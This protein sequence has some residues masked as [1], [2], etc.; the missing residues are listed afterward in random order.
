M[1]IQQLNASGPNMSTFITT[2]VA[3]LGS[4]MLCW[5]VITQHEGYHLWQSKMP[6]RKGKTKARH[7]SGYCLTA[8]MAML[9]WLLRNGHVGWLKR[10]NAW[11]GLLTNDLFGTFNSGNVRDHT[12][13]ACDFVTR[14]YKDEEDAGGAFKSEQKVYTF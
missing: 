10:S 3:I 12:R 7:T 8:R 6:H 11:I 4:T 2:A 1:N 13:K 5:F 9:I 14:Y